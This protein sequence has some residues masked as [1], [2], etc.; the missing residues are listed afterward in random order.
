MRLFIVWIMRCTGD[1]SRVEP[2][3]DDVAGG[4]HRGGSGGGTRA[5][6]QIRSLMNAGRCTNAP[7]PVA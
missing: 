5:A 1:L 7:H 6:P 2:N 3:V 4:R